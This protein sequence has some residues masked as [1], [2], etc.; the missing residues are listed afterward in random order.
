METILITGARAPVALEMARSFKQAGHR[1]IAGDALYWTIT[2]WSNT[3]DKYIVFPSPRHQFEAFRNRIMH[4]VQTERITHILP[5]CE[6]AF[7][8]SRIKSELPCTVWTAELAQ[9]NLLHS[10]LAF[11]ELAAPFFAVPQTRVLSQFTEWTQSSDY[12][13]KPIY[14]RFATSVYINRQ[15]SPDSIP[16]A[17]HPQWI[18]QRKVEGKEICVYS[19]WEQGKM[20]AF[21]AYLPLYRVG[22]GAGIFFEPITHQLIHEQVEAFGSHL[23]YHGQLCFDIILDQSGTPYVIECNPRSTSGA[24]LLHLH[25]A[26]AFLGEAS[27]PPDEQARCIRYAMLILFPSKIFNRQVRSAR[28]V[29]LRKKDF[30]P[31][32]LQPLSIL[33][34]SWIR[35][36]TRRSWLEATTGDIEWNGSPD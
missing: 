33:E 15:L 7:Y 21:A 29:I 35:L 34:I 36:R 14:S 13:F 17:N 26:T 10:K 6:E 3:V 1:V 12:V 23:S 2:R 27:P 28:D 32:L 18:A 19:I 16:P 22:R 4:L 30:L 20:K 31:S 5:T 11:I 9:M 24:H 8:F 25:L